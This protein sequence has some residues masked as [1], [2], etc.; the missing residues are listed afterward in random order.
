MLLFGLGTEW[1]FV[2]V[3]SIEVWIGLV[4][5]SMPDSQGHDRFGGG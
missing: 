4:L 2:L 5:I 1:L 3:E